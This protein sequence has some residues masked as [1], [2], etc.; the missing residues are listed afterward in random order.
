MSNQNYSYNSVALKK[1]NSSSSRGVKGFRI[2]YHHPALIDLSTLLIKSKDRY[3]A[4][5]NAKP[6]IKQLCQDR[7]FLHETLRGCLED[8]SLL[9]N[10]NQLMI[11]LIN[12][13]DIIISINFFCPIRDGAENI[14]HDNIHHH[15]WRLLTTGVMSGDGYETINFVRRS[16]ED[17]VGKIV[18]LKIKEVFRHISGE[19]RFIDSNQ[20]HVVFHNQSL[21][22]T[23]AVWSAD[24]IIATQSIK[25]RLE[26][27]PKIRKLAVKAIHKIGLNNT[28]KLNPIH[29]TY[30]HP[31]GGRIIQTE[32]YSKPF[33]GSREEV[34][35][36]WFKFFEQVNFTDVDYW[37]KLKKKVPLEAIPLINKLISN[38]PIP[39]VGILGN[40]RRYFSKT[41]IV[42][43]VNHPDQ[44]NII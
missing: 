10:A 12:S 22:S 41:Q 44:N 40:S 7:D 9:Q 27:F 13:G 34:L 37:E 6:I 39:D 11:P 3:E 42:Q 38:E 33:D 23:L 20:A 31:E 19:P 16:H 5:D 17:R 30:Y 21:C 32:N 28:L 8:P 25:R 14:T 15:G 18:K 36:C 26:Q 29:G 43:A 2:V 1:I 4:H 24:S 35:G